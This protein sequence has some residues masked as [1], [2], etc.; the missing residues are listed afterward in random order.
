M[1]DLEMYEYSQRI[2]RLVDAPRLMS[3]RAATI[4][5]EAAM[6]GIGCVEGAMRAKIEAQKRAPIREGLGLILD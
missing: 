4:T 1:T 5:V 6:F 2:M 3:I